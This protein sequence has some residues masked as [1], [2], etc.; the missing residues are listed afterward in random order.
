MRKPKLIVVG[1]FDS[2]WSVGNVSRGLLQGLSALD[3]L[4]DLAFIGVQYEVILDSYFSFT[5]EKD[6]TG[7]IPKN[8]KQLE[9]L[10]ITNEDVTILFY[11][12]PVVGI[13]FMEYFRGITNAKITALGYFI[14]ES[15][16]LPETWI[17]GL[18]VFDHIF[19]PSG[20]VS[21]ALRGS[22][23][24]YHETIPDI[25]V[26]M[27]GIDDVFIDTPY[28]KFKRQEPAKFLHITGARDFPD[29]KGSIDLINAMGKLDIGATLTIRTMPLSDNHILVRKANLV[30]TLLKR[31]VINFDYSTEPMT[32]EETYA[33]Y[34]KGWTALVQPSR[35]EAFGLCPV[36]ALCCGLPVIATECSGHSAWTWAIETHSNMHS[37]FICVHSF[38]PGPISVQGIRNGV[39]PT[40]HFNSLITAFKNAKY[41]SFNND[42]D[43]KKRFRW[44]HTLEPIVNYLREKGQ[45]R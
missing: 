27:H 38:L 8:F 33:Y 23:K 34:R 4:Y 11:G 17:T 40:I 6:A 21:G 1:R 28:T 2:N 41:L 22:A 42:K 15:S 25:T 7:I 35:A 30:N 29:R 14:C 12:Y 16:I 45:S 20:F 31:K 39:A 19:V 18:N 43:F 36:E 3:D 26:A 24:G 13:G 37:S 10:P 9:A 5:F 44:K 32:A